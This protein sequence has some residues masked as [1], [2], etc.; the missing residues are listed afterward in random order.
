M[1]L[2]IYRLAKIVDDQLAAVD[3]PDPSD[4]GFTDID[5]IDAEAQDAINVLAEIGVVLGKTATMFDPLT[6]IKR[7]QMA[8]FINRLQGYIQD[9]LGGDPD[10]FAP[11][12]LPLSTGVPATFSRMSAPRC[13]PI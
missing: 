6:N 7:D 1:A 12:S 8:S 11:N 3:L 4:Q 5:D 2:F 13:W 9:Q 10:G